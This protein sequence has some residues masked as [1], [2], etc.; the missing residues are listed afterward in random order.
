MKAWKYQND[1][2]FGDRDKVINDIICYEYPNYFLRLLNSKKLR[3][4]LKGDMKLKRS[5]FLDGKQK[6]PSFESWESLILENEQ[7]VI[8]IKRMLTSFNSLTVDELGAIPIEVMDKRKYTADIFDI[9]RKEIPV[10]KI[11]GINR[12]KNYNNWGEIFIDFFDG[13]TTA[14]IEVEKKLDKLVKLYTNDSEMF[15]ELM[16]N[17]TTYT[18]V[19]S[20]D[21]ILDK[22]YITS[23]GSHR[24]FLAKL[25]NMDSI[26]VN[27]SPII[28]REEGDKK[29]EYLKNK[30]L[31]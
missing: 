26:T 10:K 23:D 12:F 8:R 17:P 27:L 29:Y 22:Y 15:F 30:G 11:S 20:Y 14:T 18:P 16:K 9:E 13:K 24:A 2:F 4:S 7:R 31:V 19:A 21:A 5:P 1:Y 3:Y 28:T 25:I 6:Q